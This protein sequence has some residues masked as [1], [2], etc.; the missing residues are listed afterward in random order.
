LGVSSVKEVLPMTLLRQRLG[1]R[2]DYLF[3]AAAALM[4]E[5]DGRFLS[6]LP[7]KK[8][9]DYIFEGERR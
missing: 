1:L 2:K 3:L 7:C 4:I 6:H 5:D 9:I 8:R